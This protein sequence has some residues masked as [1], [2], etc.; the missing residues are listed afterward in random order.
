MRDVKNRV[1]RCFHQILKPGLIFFVIIILN[2]ITLAQ[3]SAQIPHLEKQA[4]GN[5]QLIVQD[6]PFLI[7]GGELG[8]SNASDLKYMEWFW[9]KLD[10]V[11]LNTVL[12][13]VY[14]EL[15]EPEEG[16]FDF[17]LLDG[18]I[19]KARE[20]DKHMVLLWFGSWKNS[21][22]CY[23]PL[24]V[25][26]DQKRFP[27]AV[28][29]Q[30]RGMEILSAFSANNRN[31]DARV[32]TELM[33][34]LKRIDGK[35]HTVVMIQV[36]NE[37]GMI[38]HARD[39]SKQANDEFSKPVAAELISYLQKNKNKLIPAFYDL[40]GKNGFKITGNWQDVFGAGPAAEEI[41]TAWHYARYVNDIAE[42]GKAEY[43]L[44]MYVNA[45]LI[46]PNYKP[47]QYPSGG[48]LP[49]LMD[50]WRA[51]APA[52]DFLSPDIYFPTFAEW[53][54]RY[55]QS[56]NPLFIP[57]VALDEN[58]AANAFYAFGE[59]EAIGFCPFSIEY[60]TD[61]QNAKLT[62]TYKVLRELSPLILAGQGKKMMRG[63]LL[64]EANQRDTL[65]IG[66]YRFNIAHDYTFAWA[67]HD[68]GPWPRVGGM[69]ISLAPDEF[70]IAGNGIIVTFETNPPG[71]AIVGIASIDEGQFVEGKWIAGRRMNGD[72]SHQGRHLRIPVTDIGIQRIKLYRYQ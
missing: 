17:T 36:E 44:P 25:K 55:H 31:A 63:V 30:G 71:K 40:W 13:P 22:S 33:K 48:P 10:T 47:G 8:N 9:P 72:Q 59:H 28:D 43:P 26:T 19:K 64:D 69:I 57:E 11:G 1:I 29:E 6:Q 66:E 38:P 51:G 62:K 68:E 4:S 2:S 53:C 32:F 45:A 3:T 56:G 18:I 16:K 52:I 14:W 34:Y 5:T 49:H 50:I 70:Y 23:V 12:V 37:I 61:P 20:H 39:H 46:R 27:R 42:Q 54:R 24:W 21:M 58:T 7:R 41:F 60:L 15:L 35:D 67:K 65:E